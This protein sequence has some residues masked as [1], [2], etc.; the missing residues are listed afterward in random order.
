MMQIQLPGSRRAIPLALLALFACG[1]A[2]RLA[3]LPAD[4]P[5]ILD[6]SLYFWYASD[7]RIYAKL[8]F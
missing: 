7:I 6:A 2:L 4:L 3:H 1:M 8:T 5:V